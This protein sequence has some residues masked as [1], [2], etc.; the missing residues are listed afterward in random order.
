MTQEE[1]NA[2]TGSK[3]P[4]N[5]R[6]ICR[7][8]YS[9]PEIVCFGYECTICGQEIGRMLSEDGTN[10]YGA[11]CIMTAHR[12]EKGQRFLTQEHMGGTR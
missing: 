2:R 12:M 6:F 1:F 11:A 3:T 7:A 8:S 10:F 4:V 9:K 5:S